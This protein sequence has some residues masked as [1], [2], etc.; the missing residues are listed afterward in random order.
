[1]I[2]ILIVMLFI[3][4]ATLGMLI[5]LVLARSG[6]IETSGSGDG[7]GDG[8]GHGIGDG[9]GLVKTGPADWGVPAGS[10]PTGNADQDDDMAGLPPGLGSPEAHYSP[11]EWAKI[12]RRDARYNCGPGD[13]DCFMAYPGFPFDGQR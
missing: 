5:Y 13:S 2:A 8:P 3:Q 6:A 9:V 1:M 7:S 4:L 11:V 12:D 10:I